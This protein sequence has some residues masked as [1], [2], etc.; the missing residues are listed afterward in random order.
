MQTIRFNFARA[1]GL[2][3][4]ADRVESR[5]GFRYS[6]YADTSAT[7]NGFVLPEDRPMGFVRTGLRLAGKEPVLYPDLGMELSV[8]YERQWR[9]D[10]GPYGFNQDR[11][12]ERTTDLFWLYAGLDYAW[13]NVGHTALDCCSNPISS[14]VEIGRGKLCSQPI[15]CTLM[16][17]PPVR[18]KTSALLMAGP[19]RSADTG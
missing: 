15:R 18:V 3:T 9:G 13:T 7:E 4:D 1:R 2:W 16:P 6:R 8:W 14:R 5:R 12:T 11:H 10:S 19:R 17:Q